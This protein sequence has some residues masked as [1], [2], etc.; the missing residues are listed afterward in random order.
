M[1]TIEIELEKQTKLKIMR[2]ENKV[3]IVFANRLGVTPM[4]IIAKNKSSHITDIR[5]LYCKLR[6][7]MH[8]ETYLK[9]GQ[10][11]NRTYTPVRSGVMRIN[12]L[13]YTNDKKIVAMWNRVKDIP[14]FFYNS[15][16]SV[17]HSE[18][19]EESRKPTAE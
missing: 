10:E 3:L 19:S 18:R 13:I 8:G 16:F 11:I 12:N 7:E 14:G 6:Y 15:P 17:C 5:H 1:K 4:Q 2:T 9:T